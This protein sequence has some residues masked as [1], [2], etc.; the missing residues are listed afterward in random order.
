MILTNTHDAIPIGRHS[1]IRISPAV[2][3]SRFWRYRLWLSDA[4]DAVQALIG[5]VGEV[6][7][8]ARHPPRASAVFVDTGTRT[9]AV[10]E[11]VH[12]RSVW[13]PSN[14]LDSSALLR[15]EFGPPHQV[16]FP[17][18]VGQGGGSINQERG[19]NGRW[20]GAVGQCFGWRRR[21]AMI[22]PRHGRHIETPPCGRHRRPSSLRCWRWRLNASAYAHQR[23]ADIAITPQPLA[24]GAT[25]TPSSHPETSGP[26]CVRSSHTAETDSQGFACTAPITTPAPR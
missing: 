26:M 20:P 15:A 25:G 21:H 5:P 6:H 10:R 1:P 8:P 4:V 3:N 12:Q 7:H 22:V 13:I 9:E 17:P 23:S 11:E 2:G 18:H 16:L 19:C 14:D 24:L